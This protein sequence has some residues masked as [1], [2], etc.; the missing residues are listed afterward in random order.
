M[1]CFRAGRSHVHHRYGLYEKRWLSPLPRSRS[2]LTSIQL[3]GNLSAL[4]L[5]L[6]LLVD[7]GSEAFSASVSVRLDVDDADDDCEDEDEEDGLPSLPR[8]PL[9]LSSSFSMPVRTGGC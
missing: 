1:R 3:T 7:V 9:G 5:S 8:D 2:T 6:E 4:S